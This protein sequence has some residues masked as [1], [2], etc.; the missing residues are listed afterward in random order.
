MYVSLNDRWCQIL[1][2]IAGRVV[3][4][5]NQSSARSRIMPTAGKVADTPRISVSY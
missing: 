2:K 5:D 4:L 1:Q 3:M